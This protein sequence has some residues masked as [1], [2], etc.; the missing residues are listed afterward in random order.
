MHPIN[1]QQYSDPELIQEY[2]D[3]NCR[4]IRKLTLERIEEICEYYGNL[5][6][7]SAV[8]K[9]F[10]QYVKE[11]NI[12]TTDKPLLR[13]AFADYVDMIEKDGSIHRMQSYQYDYVGKLNMDD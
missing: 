12:D 9:S 4:R 13:G 8:S 5:D 6:S 3:I 7:E 10:D 11:F 1:F 2:N